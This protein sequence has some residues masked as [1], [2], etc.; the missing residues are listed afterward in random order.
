[1][2]ISATICS[3]NSF[4]IGLRGVVDGYFFEKRQRGESPLI[5]VDDRSRNPSIRL[6]GVG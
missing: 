1:M 2:K 4:Q 6:H 3:R 5:S